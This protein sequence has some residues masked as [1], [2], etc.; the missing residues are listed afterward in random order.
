[1][2]IILSGVTPIKSGG[3]KLVFWHPEQP[4]QLIKLINSR[5]IQYMNKQWPLMMRFQRMAHYWSYLRELTEHIA[6][7]AQG[8]GQLHHLQNITGLVDTDLGLGLVMQ[9]VLKRN[10]ELADTLSDV[11]RKGQFGS[12]EAEAFEA[13]CQWLDD[14]P[15][16]IRDLAAHNVVWN[17]VNQ[18]LVIIDGVGG[19]LRPSVRSLSQ[20]YNRYSNRKKVAKLRLRVQRQLAS[21]HVA[22]AEPH[23]V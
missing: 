13:L 15:L 14:T 16:I 9:A 22:T 10:G 19:R 20:R 2:T 1:M 4:G 18:H 17:E 5:Y 7:R 23:T 11:I 8:V 12:V 3:E 21:V 6:A